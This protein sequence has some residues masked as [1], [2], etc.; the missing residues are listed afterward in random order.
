MTARRTRATRGGAPHADLPRTTDTRHPPLWLLRGGRPVAEFL[1]RRLY[2][3]RV[4]G[5]EHLPRRGPVIVAA[6]HIGVVDGP[7]LAALTPRPVHVLTKIEM[8]HGRAG[9]FFRASGQV[10]L[11]RFSVDVA[12]VRTCVRVLRDGGVAGIFPEGRRGPGNLERFHRGAAYLAL[13]TGAPVVPVAFLGTREPGAGA[14]ALPRRGGAIDVVYG[15]PYRVAAQPWPRTREQVG[16]V[17]LLLREH[18]LAHLHAARALTGQ[19][20]P[21]PL[22]PGEIEDDPQT[23]VVEQGAR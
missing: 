19:D 2:R 16:E 6:N 13:I 18:M 22:P 7:L 15:A 9:G 10:P 20:L 8:F 11:D 4:H 21:G 3:T 14:N 23:G 17:S 1:V 5:L 12:A